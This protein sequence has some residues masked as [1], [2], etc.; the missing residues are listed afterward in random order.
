MK[1]KQS[2]T[3]K[4]IFELCWAI[5]VNPIN[6]RWI[7]THVHATKGIHICKRICMKCFWRNRG[8]YCVQRRTHKIKPVI[9]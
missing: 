7:C 2:M 9:D 8:V 5:H 6:G 3:A 1:K 4:E